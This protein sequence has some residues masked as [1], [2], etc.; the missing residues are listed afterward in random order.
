MRSY[1]RR[2]RR[3]P[4]G[5]PCQEIVE[6]VTEYLEGAL[7][8]D[9]RRRFEQHISACHGCAAYLEQLRDV[10]RLLGSLGPDDVSPEAERELGAAFRHWRDSRS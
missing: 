2:R 1:L 5:L 4:G 10:R 7:S 3:P 9:V 8:D 6:L